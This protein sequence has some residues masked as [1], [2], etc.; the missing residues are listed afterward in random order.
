MTDITEFCPLKGLW[1]IQCT[2]V[3]VFDLFVVFCNKTPQSITEKCHSVWAEVKMNHS[4]GL[5]RLWGVGKTVQYFESMVTK[6]NWNNLCCLD[7]L[8][9]Y[10]ANY[11][12]LFVGGLSNTSFTLFWSRLDQRHSNSWPEIVKIFQKLYKSIN[13]FVSVKSP[14]KPD[15]N[16]L[17]Y[18]MFDVI[19]KN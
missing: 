6:K 11:I 2:I 8:I 15:T 18:K 9:L 1:G 3:M 10:L 19:T 17:S 7:N 14:Q 5:T 16:F 4:F 13:F 12:L